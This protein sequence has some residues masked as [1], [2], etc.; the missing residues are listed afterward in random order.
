MKSIA[1]QIDAS[2]ST[3]LAS[4]ATS[5]LLHGLVFLLASVTL[6]GC[7]NA[8]SGEA[9]GELFRDVGLFV[10]EGADGGLAEVGVAPGSGDADVTQQ[11]NEATGEE[12]PFELSE[13]DRSSD[14]VPKVAPEVSTLLNHSEY[15]GPTG[16]GPPSTTL[17]QL[18]GPGHPIGG[19][20]RPK[21]TGGESAVQASEAG[22][23]PR[24]GGR[25]GAG[26]TTFMNVDGVGKSVVYVVDTSSSM[27][28][29]R[30][31]FAQA[32]LK[33]SL[34]LLQP[35]QKFAVIFYNEYNERLQLR[36]QAKQEMFFATELNRQLASHEIDRVTCDRG[37]LHLPAILEALSLKPDV[38]YFLT[39]GEPDLFAA[40]LATIHRSTGSTT[41]HAIRFGDGALTS[42]TTHWMELLARQ[43][44]GEFREITSEP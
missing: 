30:L 28:G 22:G 37:T 23:A 16:D 20:Q 4:S 2:R 11:A 43:S 35:N 39:D 19:I 34:R 14:R 7:Q 40:D 8:S 1:A 33:A 31:E 26:S 12:S 18:I 13:L 3:W 42:R 10:V 17:P 44:G 6:R 9:G 25:G 21:N 29:S 27:H 15:E 38:I 5:V 36:R 32:Q 24:S 41:I